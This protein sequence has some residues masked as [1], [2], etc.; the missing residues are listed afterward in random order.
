MDEA[1]IE[2]LEEALNAETDR[3]DEAERQLEEAREEIRDLEEKRDEL[4]SAL[5][6]IENIAYK[7]T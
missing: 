1:E 2:R 5:Q 3:A 7:H 4:K 6:D